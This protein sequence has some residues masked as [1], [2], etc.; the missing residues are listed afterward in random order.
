MTVAFKSVKGS[1]NIIKQLILLFLLFPL[2]C[3]FKVTYSLL[4]RAIFAIY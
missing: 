2:S 1:C 3:Y 4:A